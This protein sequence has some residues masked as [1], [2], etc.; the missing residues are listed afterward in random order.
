VNP[1]PPDPDDDDITLML[2]ARDDDRAA[3]ATLVERH[4]KKVLN[5]FLRTGVQYDAEDLVQLTF[6]K[7]HAYRRNYKPAAKFTTFLF[8]IARQVWIDELRRRKRRERLELEM[9]QHAQTFEMD[10]EEPAQPDTLDVAALLDTLD[11]KH[12]SVIELAIFQGLPY[13]E[14]AAILR[15]PCGTVKT[16]MFHAMKTLRKYC[17]EMPGGLK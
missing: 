7:L 4:A 3:F 16:R 1:D 5:Y 17:G 15:I 14:V 13:P 11:E 9:T 10:V 12:R 2:R 8:L 6:I